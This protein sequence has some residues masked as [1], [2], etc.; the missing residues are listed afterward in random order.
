MYACY[1]D[2]VVEPFLSNK[3]TR[4]HLCRRTARDAEN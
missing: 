4:C 3:E 2:S 1:L